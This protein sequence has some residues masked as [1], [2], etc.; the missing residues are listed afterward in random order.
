MNE[1]VQNVQ[2]WDYVEDSE[3]ASSFELSSEIKFSNED[4]TYIEN[5]F[6]DSLLVDGYKTLFDFSNFKKF[7]RLISTQEK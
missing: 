5:E 6:N 1:P 2:F 4:I 3:F 7:V